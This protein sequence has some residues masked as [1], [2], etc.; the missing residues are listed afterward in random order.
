MREIIINIYDENDSETKDVLIGTPSIILGKLSDLKN[1]MD[2]KDRSIRIKEVNFSK[3]IIKIEL[4]HKSHTVQPGILDDTIN[5]FKKRYNYYVD[6]GDE[7]SAFKVLVFILG[8]YQLNKVVK[9]SPYQMPL[10]YLYNDVYKMDKL[11]NP[12]S[13]DNVEELNERPFMEINTDSLLTFRELMGFFSVVSLKLV[14]ELSK[15]GYKDESLDIGDFVIFLCDNNINKFLGDLQASGL[16]HNLII[17]LGTTGIF[18][19]T[20]FLHELGHCIFNYSANK[21]SREL[22]EKQANY[23]PSFVYNNPLVDEIIKETTDRQLNIYLNPYLY[24]KLDLLDE[25]I[26]LMFQGRMK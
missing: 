25:E 18:S 26:D 1:D 12:Y 14:D 9:L 19:K 10:L 11:V 6:E 2:Y 24:S 20:V 8:I 16:K 15:L 22:K 21:S 5:L 4:Y 3:R 23:L 13:N 17:Q 7:N